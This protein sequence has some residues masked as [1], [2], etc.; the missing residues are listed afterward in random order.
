MW[1][2]GA[3]F[4]FSMQKYIETLFSPFFCD[5]ELVLPAAIQNCLNGE[6]G[7]TKDKE[8]TRP[9]LECVPCWTLVVLSSAVSWGQS[10]V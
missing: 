1:E 7:K 4:F 10:S 9:F 5:A 3:L 2:L 8:S 6:F